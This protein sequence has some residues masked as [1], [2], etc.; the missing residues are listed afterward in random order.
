[1]KKKKDSQEIAINFKIFFF[2][3]RRY[4]ENKNEKSIGRP[5]LRFN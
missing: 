4:A 3:L 1:M 2:N 5:T